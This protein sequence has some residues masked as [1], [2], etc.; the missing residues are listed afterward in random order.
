MYEYLM[1]FD[2]ESMLLKINETVKSAKIKY[3]TWH[4][5]IS[6]SGYDREEKFILARDPK[7]LIIQMFQ[8]FDAV[9]NA[10]RN[11]MIQKVKPLYD[12]ISQ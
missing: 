4:V 10:A 11:L 5:P 12:E 9:S 1:T 2:L 6:V 3:V 8:Y 7:E